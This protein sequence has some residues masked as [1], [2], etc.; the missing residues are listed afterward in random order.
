MI[1]STVYAIIRR[2]LSLPALLLYR[3]ASKEAELLV[4]RH[5]TRSYTAG[6]SRGVTDQLTACGW[7]LSRTWC[8]ATVG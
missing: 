3:D 7:R 4:L 2:R 1:T 5:Q 8:P 6:F